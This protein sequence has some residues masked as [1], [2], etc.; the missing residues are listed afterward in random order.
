L[1]DTLKE[2]FEGNEALFEGLYIHDKWDWSRHY[3]VIKVDFAGGYCVTE[4]NW[5]KRFMAFC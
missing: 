3:P 4:P 2:L 5:I 1:V